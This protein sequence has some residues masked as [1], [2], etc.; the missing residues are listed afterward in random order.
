MKIK[1]YQLDAFTDKLFGGNPAAVCPLNE[2]LPDAWLQNIAMENNLAETA[3]YVLEKEGYRIR[4]F[5]P[6]V[7]VDLCGHATLAAAYVLFYLEGVPDSNLEFQS[8]SGKLKV[9]R[10]H[11]FLT[12]NFP[13]DAMHEVKI[14]DD[15]KNCFS[16]DPVK[17]YKGLTDYMF[18]YQSESQIEQMNA[19]LTKIA[20]LDARG[21]I[22][23]A[24]GNEVDFVSRFFAPQ[25]GI[26]EDPVTGSAHTSLT[27]YWKDVLQKDELIAVQLSKRKGFLK[28]RHLGDRVEISGKVK[29][30]MNGEVCLD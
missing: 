4:W 10:E 5:T 25:S 24:K 29:L 1:I 20:R 22:I 15:F 21:V 6:A 9:L 14:T 11:E 23:T 30:Y 16:I 27:P 28:C 3:F 19:N 2:W 18:I 13:A 26:D 7:E 8:R 12:L 17:V